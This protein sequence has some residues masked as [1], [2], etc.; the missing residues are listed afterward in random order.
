MHLVL[1]TLKR[2]VSALVAIVAIALCAFLALGRMPLDIVPHL[3]APAI[4]VARTYS[5]IDPNE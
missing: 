5:G 3:G 2:R 1:A 4:Y